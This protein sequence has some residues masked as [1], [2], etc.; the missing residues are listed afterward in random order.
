MVW[1]TPPT[2]ATGDFYTAFMWNTYMKDNTIHLRNLT[3]GADPG[4]TD[5]VLVSDGPLETDV[6]W[7]TVPDAAMANPHVRR[8][9]LTDT[10]FGAA[11]GQTGFW[12]INNPADAPDGIVGQN[13]YCMTIADASSPNTHFLQYVWSRSDVTNIFFRIVAGTPSAWAKVWTREND[14][15]GSTLNADTLDSL[16]TS[17]TG[18]GIPVAN[19]A[20]SVDLN[21]DRVDSYHAGHTNGTVAIADSAQVDF[22]NSQFLNGFTTGN[23]TGAVPVNNGVLNVNLNAEMLGGSNLAAVLA[24]AAAAS[25]KSAFGSYTGDGSFGRQITTG[26]QCKFVFITGIFSGTIVKFLFLTST[27]TNLNTHV[28]ANPSTGVLT[29]LVCDSTELHATD[30]FNVSGT[31]IDSS[32]NS[33]VVYRYAAF[34]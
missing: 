31:G 3:G 2:K 22:L 13:W 19:T 7:T 24:A 8:V 21:A 17:N 26:F 25:T 5:K 4:A 29:G 11:K 33:T 27:T 16:N 15:T 1:N 12:Q 6:T 34:G 20:L 23:G 9:N 14:G 28:I 30:G 32:N 18:G 10:S